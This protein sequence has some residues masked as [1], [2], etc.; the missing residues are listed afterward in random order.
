MMSMEKAIVATNVGG[1][2]E[3]VADGQTG[4]IVPPQDLLALAAGIDRLISD[5]V[6]LA[7]FGE[8]SYSRYR[9]KLTL[10]GMLTNTVDI[11]EEALIS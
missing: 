8:R 1:M 6:L 5:L 9:E 3:Q 7:D 10:S 4:F 11:Y 2:M